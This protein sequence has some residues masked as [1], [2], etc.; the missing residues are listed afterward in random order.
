MEDVKVK[1]MKTSF[2]IVA[3]FLL[4]A[5]TDIDSDEDATA[6]DL[7][8]R[9]VD[10]G[11][12]SNGSGTD[13]PVVVLAP[14]PGTTIAFYAWADLSAGILMKAESGGL[15]FLGAD[16]LKDLSVTEVFWA[17]SPPGTQIPLA[18]V[19]YQDALERDGERRSWRAVQG[20]S[21]GWGL[22]IPFL[23]V[24]EN[25][26][27]A[28]FTTNH[29]LPA[30]P[31]T[32]DVCAID[33]NS[34]YSWTTGATRNYKAGFC[35]DS[36]TV[37][38]Y[39]VYDEQVGGDSCLWWHTLTYIWGTPWDGGDEYT[40]NTYLSWVWAASSTTPSRSWTHHSSNGGGADNYDW[41]IR[42]KPGTIC[43]D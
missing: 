11:Y 35:L 7:D 28:T 20:E 37:N 23:R 22:D 17:L 16:E 9:V 36:G 15:D 29:C 40:A 21:Q 30:S 32:H 1:S 31:Y 14:A 25:C 6:A 24:H 4:C 27:N 18:L 26:V 19:E 5:C 43:D 39:L 13:A 34:N 10:V 33:T 38:D 42:Q 12:S 3:S 8:A 2:T 41:A